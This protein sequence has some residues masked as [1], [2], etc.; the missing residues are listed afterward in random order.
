MKKWQCL[1]FACCCLLTA[2]ATA[3]EP[4]ATAI[5]PFEFDDTS[6]QG[7]LQGPR[8]EETA[9][10]TALGHQLSAMLAGSGCCKLVDMTAAS[11]QSRTLN[12]RACGGCDIDLARQ[13]GAAVSV[14]GWVQKVSNLILNI[15]VVAR[16]VANGKVIGAASVDIRGN[17]DESWSRGLSYLVRDRLHPSQW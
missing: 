16:D 11:R 8:P 3:R 12:L 14:I 9:R 5:F 6:L 1:I 17:T 10:L 2:S 7:S 4:A 13:A 15:N